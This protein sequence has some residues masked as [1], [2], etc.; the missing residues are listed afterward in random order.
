MSMNMVKIILIFSCAR[1]IDVSAIETDDC[2]NTLIY[3]VCMVV[4]LVY[5]FSLMCCI[6]Y[7]IFQIA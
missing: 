6:I 3:I 7:H 5:L 2:R 1:E 4:K